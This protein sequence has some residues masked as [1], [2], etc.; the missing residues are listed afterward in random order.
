VNPDGTEESILFDC[1]QDDVFAAPPGTP[2]TVTGD[3]ETVNVSAAWREPGTVGPTTD[4]V[5]DAE[6]GTV[7]TYAYEVTWSDGSEASFWLLLTVQGDPDEPSATQPGFVIRFYGIGERS[8][9]EPSVTA[10]YGGETRR[11][12]TEAFEWTLPDGTTRDEDDAAGT[13]GRRAECSFD[14]LF[15]V[16]PGTPI[17]MIADTATEIVRSRTTTPFYGGPDGVGA[18][19]RWP[20]GFAEFLV[21]FEVESSSPVPPEIELACAPGDRVH[22]DP[23]SGGVIL[24]GGSLFITG[25]V[26]GFLPLDVVEQMTRETD[27]V[28]EWSGI[29][30]VV[31]DG[32]VIATIDWDRLSGTACRGSGIG[33]V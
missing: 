24:P 23:P 27:G 29:W 18:R 28:T 7:V 32:D 17:V 2:I 6:P 19:V 8:T 26:E 30:Q 25:N 1:G 14:P 21:R 11:G 3:F 9:E 12:C 31:R 13:A 16:P 5:A 20:E 15:R 4:Q 33:R 22:V 10:T